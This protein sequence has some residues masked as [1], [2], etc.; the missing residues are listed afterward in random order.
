MVGH[1]RKQKMEQAEHEAHLSHRY[2][3]KKEAL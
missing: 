2:F 3:E 1:R